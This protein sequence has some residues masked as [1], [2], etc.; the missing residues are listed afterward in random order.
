MNLDKFWALLTGILLSFVSA[1][2]AI[3]GL[4][5]IFAASFW[6]IVIM[7]TILEFG[8]IITA[9]YLYRNWDILPFL[10]KTYFTIAVAILMMITSMGVFGFLSKA[11]IEQN[12]S[13]GNVVSK[14]E[15]IDAKITRERERITAADNAL[16]QLDSAVNKIIDKDNATVALRARASQNKERAAI[17]AEI[18][19]AQ[20]TIEDLQNEKMPLSQQIR[21][22]EKEVGPIKYVSQL[23]YGESTKDDLEKAV[24]FMILALVLVLDPLALLLIV[25][26]NLHLKKDDEEE[27]ELPDIYSSDGNAVATDGNIWNTISD[28]KITKIQK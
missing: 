21:E 24:R 14:I 18:T 6:P 15:I 22:V 27:L 19:E 8:K 2:Y 7:G 26:A 3:T 12:A 25:S 16:K 10:M 20:N 9:S 5:A 11:H 28:V 23:L 17:K 13:S 1:Y 4:A